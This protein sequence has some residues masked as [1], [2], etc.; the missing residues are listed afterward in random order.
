VRLQHLPGDRREYFQAPEDVW[1]IFRTL[2]EERRKREIDP[3]LSMLRE[4]LMEQPSTEDDIH[5]QARMKQMHDLVELMT[6]WLAE[7]QKMDSTT[8]VSLMKMGAQVQ[9]LLEL[10]DKVKASFSGRSIETA[11]TTNNTADES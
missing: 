11:T 4:A 2:A 10:K 7:V 6:G 1:M 3:T 8:L 5:A 9:K